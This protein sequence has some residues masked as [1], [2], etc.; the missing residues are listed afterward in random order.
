VNQFQTATE[1]YNERFINLL[2]DGGQLEDVFI[3]R[4][5][6]ACGVCRAAPQSLTPA[7]LPVLPHR[8][9]ERRAGC[10]CWYAASSRTFAA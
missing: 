2:A 10:G 1:E 3:I 4:E 5:L 8:D 6:E 9:C 7:D